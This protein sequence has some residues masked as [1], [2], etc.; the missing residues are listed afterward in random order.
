VVQAIGGM[1][2][3]SQEGKV[4]VAVFRLDTFRQLA[5]TRREV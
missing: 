4:A 3:E 1:I 5:Q 2:K